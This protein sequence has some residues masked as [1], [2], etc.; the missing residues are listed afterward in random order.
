MRTDVRIVALLAACFVA[1]PLHAAPPQQPGSIAVTQGNCNLTPIN[2]GSG[3]LTV[4]VTADICAS[5]VDPNKAIRVRYIRLDTAS[6]SLLVAGKIDGDLARALGASP[7]IIKNKV[8]DELAELIKRFGSNLGTA[9]AAGQ[10]V[11]TTLSGENDSSAEASED[12]QKFRRRV[13]SAKIYNAIEDTALPDIDAYVGIQNTP[14]F[15]SNYA[16][17]YS[18]EPVAAD[19]SPNTV[20]NAVTLWRELT[21]DDLRNYARNT[22][23]LRSLILQ[24][25]FK[26]ALEEPLLPQN[27]KAWDERLNRTVSAMLYFARAGWPP[28]YLFAIGSATTCGTDV[29]AFITMFPR[30]LFVQVAVLDNV[31]GRGVLPVSALKAE[32][33]D[34]DRLRAADD[35]K[36]WAPVDLAFPA[37]ALEAHESIVVPLQMLLLP[38]EAMDID[39]TAT[40]AS[41]TFDQIKAF[42]KPLVLKNEKGRILYQKSKDAFKPPSFPVKVDYTYGPRLRL[43]SIVSEGKEIKLRQF[44]PLQVAMHFGFQEGSCPGIYV[45]APDAKTPVSYGRILVGAVGAERARTDI[46]WHDG[47]ALFVELAEDEPEIT[48][49]RSIRVFAVDANGAERLA[50]AKSDLF[51]MPGLP[52]RIEAPELLTAARI[53]VEVEGFYRTLPS[54]LLQN[55]NLDEME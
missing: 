39:V 45:Q 23:A 34:S 17:Y 1:S 7:F 36:D 27:A 51:V 40:D 52:L 37:G 38:S 11:S 19:D 29:G 24:R 49:V 28:N 50:A 18:G 30:H 54:L 47:P 10:T 48:R 31:Q 35:D 9:G 5:F 42:P 8:F 44:N 16:M 53:R 14:T 41:R 46:L 13:G 55:A 20:L 4:N 6:A 43:S 15:P 25:K 26:V 32:Q 2:T 12:F 21:A 3:N 22:A 33:V